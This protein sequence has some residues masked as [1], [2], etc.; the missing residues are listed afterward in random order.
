[1]STAVT[2]RLPA[3]VAAV[4]GRLL[5]D[6]SAAEVVGLAPVG[7]GIGFRPEQ[8]DGG[9]AFGAYGLR[10]TGNNV[11]VRV[12]T[13][14]MAEAT[15]EFR[16]VI[17][18]AADAAG[19]RIVLP[20]TRGLATL[21]VAGS[22]R[23]LAAPT[24]VERPA[25]APRCRCGARPERRRRDRAYGTSMSFVRVGRLRA[26]IRLFAGQALPPRLTQTATVAST[27]WMSRQSSLRRAG[28]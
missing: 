27:S 16:L 17:D 25:S 26:S 18:S 24:A 15:I 7:G 8:I 13:A 19:K 4:D 28:T 3:S 23:L 20:T 21:S 11:I 12:V 1:M 10:P 5:F 9:V 14:P 22:T 6:T 2:F